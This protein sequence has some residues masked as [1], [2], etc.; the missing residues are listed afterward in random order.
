MKI[1]KLK[2]GTVNT[3][4]KNV[5][6]KDN[7][8]AMSGL[9]NNQNKFANLLLFDNHLARIKPN[10]SNPKLSKNDKAFLF[11]AN[12]QSNLPSKVNLTES[13]RNRKNKSNTIDKKDT[14]ETAK[15]NMVKQNSTD[16]PHKSQFSNLNSLKNSRGRDK[17]NLSIS[18]KYK[19]SESKR[20]RDYS[21]QENK[22]KFCSNFKRSMDL[23]TID[24]DKANE[25]AKNSSQK[26]MD[27]K[28]K[29]IQEKLFLI[30]SN[31]NYLK[32]IQKSKIEQPHQ[33]LGITNLIVENKVEDEY[34]N[35]DNEK[36]L[37]LEKDEKP[38]FGGRDMKN[39]TKI[40]LLGK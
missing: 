37:T 5:K 14:E 8:M 24:V 40:K 22:N 9:S 4:Q 35:Y 7:Q 6:L 21:V 31:H 17:R 28:K 34:F 30:H 36:P 18:N 29:L 16:N 33:P 15:N 2:P 27:I 12:Q 3:K 32:N 23:E 10:N 19:F 20:K 26:K 38:I 11:Q 13:N 1:Q 25:E 39:Y